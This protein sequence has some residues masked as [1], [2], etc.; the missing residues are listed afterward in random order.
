[1]FSIMK[2]AD[3]RH[4]K[5]E[6]GRHVFSAD[7]R[8]PIMHQ[9][10]ISLILLAVGC[11]PWFG[12]GDTADPSEQSQIKGTVTDARGPVSGATVRIQT[13]EHYAITG[14]DGSYVLPVDE[15]GDG[16]F[17]ITAWA[18]GYYCAGPVEAVS[19]QT[20]A[21]II[22]SSH[23]TEDNRDYAWLP[24]EHH[25]G[26]GEDQG[27]AACHSS[28]GTNLG[29]TLPVD[30]WRQDAHSRS[31]ANERFVTMYEGK[32]I[33]G[34]QSPLTR[35]G[36]HRDYGRFPLPP[37]P[38]EP[39]YGPGYRLDFPDTAG[40]CGAC[41]VPLAAVNDP[42]NVDVSS[43]TGVA[44][45]GVSCDFCHKIWDVRLDSDKGLPYEN[46]PGVLSFEFRRPPEGHQFFAGPFDDVAPGED[47]FSPLQRQ[48]EFCAP[49]HFGVF[50]DSVV[51][52]SFGEWLDS[53]Y[54]DPQTGQT[55][56]DCHM[57]HLG[58]THFVRPNEG[59]LTRNP[60]TIFS[61]RMPGASDETLLQNAVTMTTKASLEGDK[62][63]VDV[64]IANDQTGHH[65]P[66]DSPLRHLLL[67]VEV[68]DTNGESLP[69]LEGS[70]VP[71]WGGVGDPEQ[72]Y[73]AGLPGK[74]FAKVLEELWTEVSPTGAYW[75]PTRVLSDNR[76][77]AL[78]TDTSTYTFATSQ[79][80]QTLINVTL[81][82][83]R[84]FKELMDQKGWDVSDIVMEEAQVA[85]DSGR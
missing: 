79:E 29:F 26:E 85:L 3:H 69:L 28:E 80:G 5:A 10:S 64:E 15:L 70:T 50:W 30:E 55:C 82:F 58:A 1:M 73:Y 18:T 23:S 60:N 83:R 32:D 81:L 20:G 36:F 48:S 33:H 14:D 12:E 22:L 45:E 9:Y 13:T 17:R 67:L 7:R 4:E 84:A 68:T 25:P 37:D 57:P 52:N 47:T 65:V 27:C 41:H 54:S 24:S 39:Y 72:G 2:M 59:G 34:N 38:E 49:C 44:G 21:D 76:I 16:P 19:G 62:V 40:N 35:H 46:M 53:P 71:E 77:A 11:C 43:V 6:R 61:H 66:T 75:N 51:Y 8:Q 74:G 56:Q 63:R 78:A 31:A 42:Y